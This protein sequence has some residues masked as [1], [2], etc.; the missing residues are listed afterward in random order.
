MPSAASIAPAR[1]SIH[2]ARPRFKGVAVTGLPLTLIVRRPDG[3]EYRRAAV[4]DQGGGGRALSLPLVSGAATGTWRVQAYADPKGDAIGETSFLVEDYVPERLDADVKPKRTALR[5]GEPAE[6][7][8]EARYLYGAP[9]AE[10][11]VGGSITVRPATQHAIPGLAGYR[12]G[13]TDES[14]EAVKNDI[15]E[16]ATTDAAG[17]ASLAVTLTEPETTLPLEAEIV[18]SIS[19]KRRPR[20]QPRRHAAD[21]A[22]GQRRRRQ[23]LFEDGT[24]G[25]G[26][27]A[28]FDVVMATGE[29][30]R[31]ARTGVKWTLS[32][33]Q[34]N[35]QWFFQDGKWAYEA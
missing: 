2:G 1:R 15:D 20:H 11:E 4:E 25:D 12:I 23:G 22:Q 16:K 19:E 35:Y 8:V 5:S 6:L 30:R 31:L 34:R 10:L 28:G 17:K 24:L 18:V 29:G 33:V 14:V 7:D 21:P 27:T 26:Q 9:G 13:L 3:V 32:R